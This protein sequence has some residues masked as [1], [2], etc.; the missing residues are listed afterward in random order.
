MEGHHYTGVNNV[1]SGDTG[2]KA[3][4]DVNDAGGTLP[5]VSIIA[6]GKFST[7]AISMVINYNNIILPIHPTLRKKISICHRRH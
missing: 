7:G 1:D 3:A 5:P 6:G 4:T 2:G